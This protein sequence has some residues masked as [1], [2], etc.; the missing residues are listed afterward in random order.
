MADEGKRE[1]ETP[2]RQRRS[3]LRKPEPGKDEE[4]KRLPRPSVRENSGIR[5][6]RGEGRR[7]GRAGAV[8]QG[9]DA[10]GEGEEG[11]SDTGRAREDISG[12]VAPRGPE[13]SQ[14]LHVSLWLG[15]LL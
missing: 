12:M 6:Q 3:A 1:L 14:S 13:G 5:T 9:E 7:S 11:L 4:G 8:R 2:E 15:S 10:G